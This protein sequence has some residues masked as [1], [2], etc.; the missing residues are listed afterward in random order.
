MARDHD[1]DSVH[2]VGR[3]D[4]PRRA[5]LADASRHVAVRPRL[6]VRDREQRAPDL[7]LE[8]RAADHQRQVEVLAPAREVLV[9]LLA[10]PLEPAIAPG[11]ERGTETLAQRLQLRLE[12]APVA[13]LEQAHAFARGTRNERA[14][15]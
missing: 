12:H 5:G 8:R 2:A 7:F 4:G 1:R 3:A 9:E 6:A 14:H 15:R 11:H 13:E 10:Q